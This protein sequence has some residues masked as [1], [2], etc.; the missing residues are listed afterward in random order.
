MNLSHSIIPKNVQH[1][2]QLGQ[3]FSLLSNDSE[4]NTIQVNKNI[5]N[6]II[7]NHDDTQSEVRN[8][9]LPILHNLKSKSLHKDT[10]DMQ[11][12]ELLRRIN[13]Y[14]KNNPNVIFTRADKDNI[15]VALDIT[16]Y[17]NRI[18]EMLKNIHNN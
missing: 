18:E 15:T 11:I 13:K 2:L 9:S 5:E 10:K 8:R 1:L 3:N 7:N 4:N 17:C 12:L 16:E 14:I 6:N